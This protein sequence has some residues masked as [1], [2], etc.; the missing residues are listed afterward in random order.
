MHARWQALKDIAVGHVCAYPA[1]E[2]CMFACMLISVHIG[3]IEYVQCAETMQGWLWGGQEGI[4]AG[5][6]SLVPLAC[7]Q[8][9]E[10]RRS[11]SHCGEVAVTA[12]D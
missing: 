6:V 5:C 7:L 12:A 11:A 9:T 8:R 1:C 4:P 2:G 3:R 10:P